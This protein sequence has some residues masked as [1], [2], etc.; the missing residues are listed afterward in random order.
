MSP[1]S[2]KPEPRIYNRLAVLRAEHGLTRQQLADAVDVNV[3]TIG[4]LERG[5]YNP[6]LALAFAIAARFGLPID[7]VFSPTPFA[8][9]S[10]QLYGRPGTP[11]PSQRS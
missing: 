6:S 4:Y 1:N 10:Q 9:M 7:A 3:Q 5:D 8:P 11:D 2:R